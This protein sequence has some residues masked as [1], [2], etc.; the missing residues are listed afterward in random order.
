MFLNH[1]R[2]PD[3]N[4]KN[5]Y[6]GNALHICASTDNL[7]CAE[8]LLKYKANICDRCGNGFYPIHV[9]AHSCANKVIKLLLAEGKIGLLNVLVN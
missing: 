3:V 7:E 6:G 5:K 2:K 4:T 9:A 1:K 8:I